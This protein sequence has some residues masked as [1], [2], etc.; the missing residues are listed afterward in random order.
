MRLKI[1]E[2]YLVSKV[3]NTEKLLTKKATVMT[4]IVSEEELTS[5]ATLSWPRNKG[6][7]TTCPFSFFTDACTNKKTIL[8]LYT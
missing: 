2:L 4:R 5:P 7:I 3:T 8:C 1:R 6:T